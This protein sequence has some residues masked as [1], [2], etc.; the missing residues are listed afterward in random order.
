[1]RAAEL[2][3]GV[4]GAPPPP[5]RVAVP[6]PLLV[7][8]SATSAGPGKGGPAGEDAH[9]LLPPGGG[10]PTA[11]AASTVGAPTVGVGVFDGVGGWRRLGID[12]GD[13]ARALAAGA[14]AYLAARPGAGGAAV[15]YGRWAAAEALVSAVDAVTLAGTATAVVAAVV[16]DDDD[17]DAAAAGGHAAWAAAH[18][19]G[20]RPRRSG[21]RLVGVAVGDSGLWVIR[22]GTVIYRSPDGLFDNVWGE[23]VVATATAARGGEGGDV[24]AAARRLHAAAVDAYSRRTYRS[25][26]AVAARAAGWDYPD[27][28]KPDDVVVVVCRAEASNGGKGGGTD[29]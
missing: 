14:A 15:V 18:P 13:Y 5:P 28:G 6:P 11:P 26:F 23:A 22:A 27:A 1:M 21:R 20:G 3:V 16:A 25:P 12:A 9:F 24:A 17:D 8:A 29:L 4:H 19:P 10:P 2:Q 7:C